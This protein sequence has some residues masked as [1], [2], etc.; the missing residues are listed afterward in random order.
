MACHEIAALRLGLMRLLGLKDE[1]ARQHEL[2]E[3]G[4]G[5]SQPGPIRA[6]C[7]AADLES[8]R[9]FYEAAVSMLEERVAGTR[10][11]DMK[12]PYLRSL[13]I[14]TKKVELDLASQIDNLTRLFTELEQMHDFVHEIYP[15]D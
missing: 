2:A 4:D 6:M 15:A 7:D 14:L 11:E 9:R 5:A 8:L 1:A 3:L 12:L 10:P 13:I